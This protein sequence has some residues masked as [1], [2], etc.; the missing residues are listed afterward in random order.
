MS[1]TLFL[2]GVDAT[3]YGFELIEAPDLLSMGTHTYQTAA[4]VQRAGVL[5][6]T[7]RPAIEPR[8]LRLIG[9]INGSSLS[10]AVSKLD[11]LKAQVNT[12]PCSIRTAWDTTRQYWGVLVD[13]PAG[14]NSSYWQ[15]YL[16]VELEFLLF[17]PLAYSTSSST[18]NFT[19]SAVAVPLGTATSKGNRVVEAK[20]RITGAATTPIL[21]YKNSDGVTVSTMSFTGYSPLANDYIEIN[22][23]LG[24]VEK[25]VSGVRSNA[26]GA[27][28]PGWNFPAIDPQDGNY[29]LAAWP[30]LEVTSGSGQLTYTKAYR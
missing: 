7:A 6:G 16:A 21:T 10:N 17:D 12:S 5:L 23:S 18:V 11:D 25:V 9:Y 26:M 3:T 14:P 29:Q 24:L 28:A 27:L 8:V 15:T 4:V 1:G 19:T 13:S 20:I 2:N 22:L 30:T